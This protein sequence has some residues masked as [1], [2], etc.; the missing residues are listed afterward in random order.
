MWYDLDLKFWCIIVHHPSEIIYRNT[1]SLKK[2]FDLGI[3]ASINI[4][5]NYLILL[6]TKKEPCKMPSWEK[7]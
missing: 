4:L 5:Q 7:S 1:I 6:L 2:K 3:R